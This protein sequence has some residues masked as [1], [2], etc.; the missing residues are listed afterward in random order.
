[1]FSNY[2]ECKIAEDTHIRSKTIK[3][4]IPSLFPDNKYQYEPQE[5]ITN[6]SQANRV[7]NTN[8]SAVNESYETTN[9]IEALNHTNYMYKLK[10]DVFKDRMEYTDG[11]TV[12]KAGG[13]GDAAYE[14]HFHKIKD[15]ITLYNF[16]FENLNNVIVKKGTL[17]YGFF[18]NGSGDTTRFAITHIE[19]A[20]PLE[21]ED[22]IAYQK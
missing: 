1:M 13:S 22:P 6:S 3:V 15:P 11:K 18:I 12:P 19:D 4:I 8:K 21:D 16:V 14:E 20:R 7:L 17:A 9:V 2:M 5:S 10:G